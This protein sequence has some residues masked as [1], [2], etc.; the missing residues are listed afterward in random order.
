[1]AV[2]NF[3]DTKK[4]L[5]YSVTMW[6]WQEGVS[7]PADGILGKNNGGPG[8]SG[9]GWIVEILPQI[10]QQAIHDRILAG[11]EASEGRDW[12][13][14]AK[15]GWGMGHKDLRDIVTRQLPILTCPSDPSAASNNKQWHWRHL[16]MDVGVTSYKGVLGD[17][18]LWPQGNQFS[19]LGGD[20][21]EGDC[22]NV[23]EVELADGT[24]ERCNGLF[25]RM[26]YVD[27]IELRQISDGQSNTFMIGETVSSQDYHGAAFFA[28][29]DWAVCSVPLNFF[30][31][32]GLEPDKVIEDWAQQRG[33]RSLHPGGAQ[34]VFADGSVHF[35]V[36]DINRDAYRAFATRDGGEVASFE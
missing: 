33:F 6:G 30:T 8:Y 20:G 25:W 14:V 17:N 24:R 13:A 36:E 10:E 31:I 34:F 27:P 29:G 16:D 11:I 35:I 12:L 9:R 22:H 32:E 26:A 2:L 1:L 3:E 4:R 5:P 7:D 15:G 28:D 18:E 19:F 21:S 23:V